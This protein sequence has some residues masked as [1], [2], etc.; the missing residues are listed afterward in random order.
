MIIDTGGILKA[1]TALKRWIGARTAMEKQVFQ[2]VKA[3]G[4]WMELSCTHQAFGSGKGSSGAQKLSW[5][6]G[7]ASH[8]PG[9]EL[10]TPGKPR[11][12]KDSLV[13]CA[14]LHLRVSI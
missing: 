7:H 10:S 2:E 4:N 9:S 1:E 12:P 3:L 14:V 13:S 6:G 11:G 5:Y 8:Q